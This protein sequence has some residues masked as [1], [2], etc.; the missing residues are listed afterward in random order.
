MPDPGFTKPDLCLI[1]A[2]A[3]RA[4]C[5]TAARGVLSNDGYPPADDDPLAPMARDVVRTP[6]T[7]GA[8]LITGHS[9]RRTGSGR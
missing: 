5:A 4:D 6:G 8:W 1:C 9:G 2:A 7:G 3:S